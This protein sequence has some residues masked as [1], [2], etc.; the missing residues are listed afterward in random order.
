MNLDQARELIVSGQLLS[1]ARFDEFQQGWL[2]GNRQS[3]EGAEFVR[4]LVDERELTDFQAQAVLA[5]IPGPYLLGPY[6]VTARITAGRL[7]DVY[8]AEHIEF[9]QPVSLKV[10]PASLNQDPELTARLGREARVSLQVDSP[11][12]VKTYQVGRVGAIPFIALESLQG[13][14]LEQRLE[15]DGR[16]PHVEACQLI[17]QAAHGLAYVHSQEIMHRDICP[18]NLW[19][20]DQGVVKIMDFGAARD[21]LSFVDSLDDS[22]GNDLTVD[23]SVGNVLGHYSYMS[24][25]QAEDP[26]TANVSSDLYSLGCTFFHCLTGQ[27]PFPDKNPVRQ[28][29]RHANEPPRPLTDFVPEMPQVVQEVVSYLLAK[30]PEDR[31]GSADEV[32]AALAAIIPLAALP[33]VATVAPDFLQWVQTADDGLFGVVVAEPEEP[34]LQNFVAWQIGRAHV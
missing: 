25:E 32:S 21:A 18:A 10:F 34:E 1:P 28:M 16:I 4:W 19:V 13:E 23:L 3:E 9:Q 30:R 8:H 5:G 27:V 31:Y 20:S 17:Q 33:T 11:Y 24:A 12:V 2:E 7:G 22:D 29:L 26:H 15:R 6:R 14:T